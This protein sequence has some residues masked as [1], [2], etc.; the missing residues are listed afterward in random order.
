MER[1]ATRNQTAPPAPATV[2]ATTAP[3]EPAPS[4]PPSIPNPLYDHATRVHIEDRAHQLLTEAVENIAI[5]QVGE[6]FYRCPLNE[7]N[8]PFRRLRDREMNILNK[9]RYG[10]TL[11]PEDKFNFRAKYEREAHRSRAFGNFDLLGNPTN[12]DLFPSA[13]L[14]ATKPVLP[15]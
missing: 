11:G 4:L 9:M 3:T 10:D 1:T 15:L 2:P 7:M 14:V 6:F 8:I 12:E 5:V 13:T